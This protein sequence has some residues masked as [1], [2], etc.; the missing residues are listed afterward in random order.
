MLPL[1]HAFLRVTGRWGSRTFSSCQPSLG[2]FP[3]AR[4]PILCLWPVAFIPSPD[5]WPPVTPQQWPNM[6]NIRLPHVHV[7]VLSL[8]PA[9]DPLNPVLLF[10]ASA[11]SLNAFFPT[12]LACLWHLPSLFISQTLLLMQ[13]TCSKLG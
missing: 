9:C 1:P 11:P 2:G 10:S 13:Q 5:V 3:L 6:C 4:K 8:P 7:F 12:C